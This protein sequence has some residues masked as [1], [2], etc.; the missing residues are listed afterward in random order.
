[1]SSMLCES[2]WVPNW[3]LMKYEMCVRVCVFSCIIRDELVPFSV[4]SKVEHPK[5]IGP[6]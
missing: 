6:D 2:A 4:R 5:V 3:L 1:M